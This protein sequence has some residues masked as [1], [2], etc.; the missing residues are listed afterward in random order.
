METLNKKINMKKRI[1]ILALLALSTLCFIS[2]DNK[3][4]YCYESTASGVYEQEVYISSDKPCNSMN[5]GDNYACVER[6][7]RLNPEDIAK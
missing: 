7:E 3:L 6:S 1:V 2:C 4:C 5:R